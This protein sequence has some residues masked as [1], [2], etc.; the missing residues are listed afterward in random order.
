MPPVDTH[1]RGRKGRKKGGDRQQL[2]RN[3]GHF[4]ASQQENYFLSP[5]EAREE[6]APFV[7][8][9]QMAVFHSKP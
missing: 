1:Q 5:M 6:L 2:P 9:S 3:G 8:A 4:S 7:Q